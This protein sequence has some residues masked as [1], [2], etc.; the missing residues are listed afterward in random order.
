MNIHP[1]TRTTTV[2]GADNPLAYIVATFTS[3]GPMWS[4]EIQYCL[5]TDLWHTQ[6]F[7]TNIL[8]VIATHT[9]DLRDEA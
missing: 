9:T 7:T 8:G 5:D 2:E 1:T 3:W 4:W 6:R